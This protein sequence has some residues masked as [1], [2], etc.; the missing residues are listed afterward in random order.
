M[1]GRAGDAW[2]CRA[3][4]GRGPAAKH[5]GERRSRDEPR[6][7]EWS[8]PPWSSQGAPPRTHRGVGGNR[9]N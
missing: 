9:G 6:V 5:L 3:D 4:E 2:A 1:D 7:P 8:N